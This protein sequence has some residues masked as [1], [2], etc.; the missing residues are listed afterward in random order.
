MFFD[1]LI[2]G[3]RLIDGSGAP[4]RLAEIGTSGDRITAVASLSAVPDADAGSVIDATGHVVEPGFVDPHGHPD[5][6]VL[7]DGALAS[8]A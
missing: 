4:G 3:G 6:S 2:R 1:F 7:I 5:S 8:G